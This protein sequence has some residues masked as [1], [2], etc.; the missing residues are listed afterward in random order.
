MTYPLPH[1]EIVALD[2]GLTLHFAP[3]GQQPVTDIRVCMEGGVAEHPGVPEALNM[4]MALLREGTEAHSALEI[5][6]L[7]DT[8]SVSLAAECDDHHHSLAVYTVSQALPLVVPL[9]TEMLTRPT[10]E[11]DA[12]ARCRRAFVNAIKEKRVR[13]SSQAARLSRAMLRG[14]GHPLS[15]E[16][17]EEGVAT[18]SRQQLLDLYHRLLAPRSDTHIYVCG[19]YTPQH[20]TLVEDTFAAL[21]VAGEGTERRITPFAPQAGSLAYHMAD[22]RQN[23]LQMM[24]PVD[25][26]RASA[27]YPLLRLAVKALGG[28]FSSRLS[29]NI[30]ERRGY[31]YGI[32]AA[33]LGAFEGTAVMVGCRCDARYSR[34]V[35]EETLDE[36]RRMA[37]EPPAGDE[38][39]RLRQR[40]RLDTLMALESARAV[41]AEA[42]L[43]QI[44]GVS[45]HYWLLRQQAAEGLTAEALAEVWRRYVDPSRLIVAEAGT[46]AQTSD[47]VDASRRR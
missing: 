22:Q 38:L 4:A 11:E 18:Y 39:A 6:E 15:R 14:Q 1:S 29:A 25:I 46:I 40:E 8:H 28:Y 47:A 30:R 36:V 2:N 17:T 23:A 41:G 27:D 19:R 16:M 33:L 37:Q 7:F 34:R 44:I 26:T 12:L 5:A 43:P 21:P 32:S 24:L 9:I 3:H 45:P 13:P 10:M 42:T 35:V 20:R 31:T